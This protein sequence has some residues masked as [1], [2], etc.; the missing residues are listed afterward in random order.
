MTPGGHA[1]TNRSWESL[2]GLAPGRKSSRGCKPHQE[3]L[4]LYWVVYDP[5]AS[6][7]ESS[8]KFRGGGVSE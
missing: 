5:R 6:R 8:L 3:I 2:A 4:E 7:L 1:L